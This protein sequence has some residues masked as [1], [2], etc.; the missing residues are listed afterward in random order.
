MKKYIALF[1]YNDENNGYGIVFP[2]VPGCFSAGDDYDDAYRMA[3]EALAFHL[4]GLATEGIPIPEPRTL[5]E[6]KNEWD[7]WK[8]WGKKIPVFGG[9]HSG[10][11]GL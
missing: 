5:E 1:E 9:S 8:E 2:D 7:E 3:H 4:D 10:F 6:I 11:S